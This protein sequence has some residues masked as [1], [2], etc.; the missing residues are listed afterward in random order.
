MNEVYPYFID[1]DGENCLLQPDWAT[2][3][4]AA[5]QDNTDVCNGSVICETKLLS[6]LEPQLT[7]PR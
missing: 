5:V 3:H 7:C 2:L 1:H 6:T 4:E